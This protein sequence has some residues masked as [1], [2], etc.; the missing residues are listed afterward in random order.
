VHD[1]LFTFTWLLGTA[2]QAGVC[3]A[4]I[5]RKLCRRW[6]SMLTFCLA[7][8]AFDVAIAFNRQNHTRYF[9]LYWT[10][11]FVMALFRLWI[12][13]DVLRSIPGAAL[14]EPSARLAL[15]VAAFVIA[16]GSWIVTAHD[17]T[18]FGRTYMGMTLL[19]DRCSSIA[20]GVF[21]AVL[22]IGISAS[23]LG[24]ERT[25]ALVSLGLAVKISGSIATACLFSFFRIGTFAG[26]CIQ[27]FSSITA[28]S[29]WLFALA[30]VQQEEY[31]TVASLSEI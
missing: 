4:I 24:W 29:I 28:L 23:R 22:L 30:T 26:N 2:I 6:P 17:G 16:A 5:W 31:L 7:A 18:I 10:W 9:Y 12:M 15:A 8:L 20:S 11:I 21:F 13:A 27:A 19:T 1:S 14:W 25:G 3:A